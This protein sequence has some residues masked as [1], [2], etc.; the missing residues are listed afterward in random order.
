[1]NYF[2][3]SIKIYFDGMK[4]YISEDKY[5]GNKILIGDNKTEAIKNLE[6]LLHEVLTDNGKQ[7]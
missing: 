7:H 4:V 2:P 3:S 5:M 1:M 6:R